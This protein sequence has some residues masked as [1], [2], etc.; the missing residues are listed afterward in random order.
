[1]SFP[2]KTKVKDPESEKTQQKWVE[3]VHTDGTIDLVDTRAVGGNVNDLPKGYFWSAQFV[4]TVLV[5][6]YHLHGE[7]SS[8]LTLVGP[9]HFGL[10]GYPRLNASRPS[11]PT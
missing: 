3:L 2:L 6:T 9:N 8:T 1:M 10:A 4:G 7:S 11:S 5:R